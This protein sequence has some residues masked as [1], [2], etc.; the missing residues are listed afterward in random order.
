MLES[1][2]DLGAQ[3]GR[4]HAG[5]E[6][7]YNKLSKPQLLKETTYSVFICDSSLKFGYRD[8]C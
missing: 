1:C 2:Q 7:T 3:H 8:M 5:F 6:K 4:G